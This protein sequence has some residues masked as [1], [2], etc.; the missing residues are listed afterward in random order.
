MRCSGRD[1]SLLMVTN[2]TFLLLRGGLQ[3]AHGYHDYQ[4]EIPL[5]AVRNDGRALRL[6]KVLLPLPVADGDSPLRGQPVLLQALPG[7]LRL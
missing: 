1:D 3:F 7:S 4:E 5:H 6:R 2:G